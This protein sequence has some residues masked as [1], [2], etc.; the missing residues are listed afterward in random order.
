[1]AARTADDGAPST[2]T[3]SR[4]SPRVAV[5]TRLKPE[6]QMNPVLLKP[7]TDSR[8]QVVVLGRPV[9]EMAPGEA[10]RARFVD[11]AGTL[12]QVPGSSFYRRLREKFG[13][14]SR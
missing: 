13:R 6:A 14:L 2:T 7:G 9:G 4:L 12:A 8:S 10:A 11:R 5:A 1:M 3:I